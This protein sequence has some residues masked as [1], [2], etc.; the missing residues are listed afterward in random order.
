MGN[1]TYLL[2][3]TSTGLKLENS[4]LQQTVQKLK[5][6]ELIDLQLGSIFLLWQRDAKTTNESSGF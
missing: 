1:R 6:A 2:A 5:E 3:M 4:S